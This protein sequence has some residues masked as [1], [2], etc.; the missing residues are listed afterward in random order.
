[1]RRPFAVLLAL[2]V[3]AACSAS[4]GNARA[5]GSPVTR[6]PAAGRF[7]RPPELVGEPCGFE[8][9]AADVWILSCS[10]VLLRIPKT[11]GASTAQSLGGEV[12]SLDGL[13]RGNEDALVALLWAAKRRGTVVPIATA[14]GTLGTAIDAGG[15]APVSAAPAGAT[16]WVGLVDGRLIAIR[17]GEAREAARTAPLMWVV[18]EGATL[19]T[20]DEN[21]DAAER[22]GADGAV[23]STA[24][25][26]VPEPIAAAAAFGAL[27]TA[28]PSR[29]VR[30]EEGSTTP[31]AVG[32]S[33]TVNAIEPCA[34]AVWLSQPDFG[35]RSVA[36]DRV[37]TSALPLAVAPR[38]L[39]CDGE[40]LWV[41][42]EDGRLGSIRTSS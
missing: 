25:A 18:A 42:A 3:L 31:R 17:D 7:E 37:V 33:G 22:N 20:I 23:R 40:L 29:V 16:L 6:V 41:L 13:R 5:K 11:G 2:G 9:T 8:V 19:W 34:G 15:S 27:W 21:G 36:P 32:V 39:A 14:A 35:L 24:N 28:N 30:I 4:D 10:G 26:V 12:L 38:Y 1:M